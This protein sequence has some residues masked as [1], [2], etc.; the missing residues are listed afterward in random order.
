ML[1]DYQQRAISA[2]YAWFRS[3]PAGNPVLELPTGA[4]K[5]HIVAQLCR[6][7]MAENPAARVLML[8][9]QKELIEQN[10][11]KAIV[12]DAV[13]EA[14]HPDHWRSKPKTDRAEYHRAYYWLLYKSPSPRD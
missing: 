14:R 6:D 13:D 5:S 1:R 4:G 2:L 10:A 9:H 12:M 3:I 7:I 8:T 11:G